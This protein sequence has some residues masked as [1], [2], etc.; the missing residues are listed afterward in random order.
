MASNDT[1]LIGD[2]VLSFSDDVPRALRDDILD[3]L[4]YAQLSA[5]KK[6][7][8]RAQWRLWIEQYQRIIL[9]KGGVLTG[10]IDPIR[11]VIK[12]LRDLQSVPQQ[13]SGRATSPELR[14][15]MRTSLDILLASDHAKIFFDSWF[16]AGRSESFQ[17]VPCQMD[18]RGGVTIMVC[19]LHMTTTAVSD[20]FFFWHALTGE[21]TIRPNGAS[22]RFTA[23]GYAPYRDKIRS[24][25][26]E[27]SLKTIEIIQL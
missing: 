19:G 16:S 3:C 9:Q 8:K 2:G 5:D 12:R 1:F 23:Q 25:L 10:A 22:F 11:L 13:I 17:V 4:M 15:L 24:Y 18:D 20:A 7:E 21:M 6:H 27:N 26:S 14:A